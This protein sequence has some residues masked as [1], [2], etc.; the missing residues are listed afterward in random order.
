MIWPFK[1]EWNLRQLAEKQEAGTYKN[2]VL[3]KENLILINTKLSSSQENWHLLQSNYGDNAGG[4]RI[5]PHLLLAIKFGLLEWPTLSLRVLRMVNRWRKYIEPRHKAFLL[6]SNQWGC[7]NSCHLK[8]D[9]WATGI[10]SCQPCLKC[11]LITS[12]GS[13]FDMIPDDVRHLKFKVM[14]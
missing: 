7:L 8:C 4:R 5:C 11:R 1:K 2:T 12:A 3:I 6:W 10:Q 14:I 13:E 9:Q